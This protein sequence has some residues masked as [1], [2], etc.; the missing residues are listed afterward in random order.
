MGHSRTCTFQVNVNV[1]NEREYIRQR[2]KARVCAGDVSANR[3][4][5]GATEKNYSGII[6]L[7]I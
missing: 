4:R 3:I 6:V 7:T 2:N 1:N 5:N